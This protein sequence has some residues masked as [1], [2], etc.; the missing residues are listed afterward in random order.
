MSKVTGLRGPNI[1]I[2]MVFGPQTLI[3]V[4]SIVFCCETDLRPKLVPCLLV[5]ADR[6]IGRVDRV[7]SADMQWIPGLD[8]KA[9]EALDS[10]LTLFS[11]RSSTSATNGCG[12]AAFVGFWRAQAALSSSARRCGFW[13]RFWFRVE[14]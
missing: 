13:V 6:S 14:G 4:P 3:G 10:N 11:T 2:L 1:K 12:C 5:W 8:S 9:L 7:R